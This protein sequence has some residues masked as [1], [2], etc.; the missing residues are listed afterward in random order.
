MAQLAYSPRF[1]T[2]LERKLIYIH[3]KRFRSVH[4]Y[5]TS[6]FAHNQ[7]S[8]VECTQSFTRIRSLIPFFFITKTVFA[9][10]NQSQFYGRV[11]IGHRAERYA[12]IDEQNIFD[13]IR[14]KKLSIEILRALMIFYL[15]NTFTVC[16]EATINHCPSHV[17]IILIVSPENRVNVFSHLQPISSMIRGHFICSSCART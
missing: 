17:R 14:T 8:P 13:S 6:L 2:V 1:T 7:P 15:R 5:A 12:R 10:R 4:C 11:S 3:Y 16:P 9:Q